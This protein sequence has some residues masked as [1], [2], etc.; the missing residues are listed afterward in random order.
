MGRYNNRRTQQAAEALQSTPARARFS[1]GP[2]FKNDTKKAG[3]R[4]GGRGAGRGGDH[5]GGRGTT[6]TGRRGRGGGRTS[7]TTNHLHVVSK[8]VQKVAEK[9]LES[10]SSTHNMTKKKEASL[11]GVDI[12]KLDEIVLSEETIH[13]INTILGQLEIVTGARRTTNNDD[14]LV[15][16]QSTY[17]EPNE[18]PGESN[19]TNAFSDWNGQSSLPISDGMVQETGGYT[20]YED[21]YDDAVDPTTNT[22]TLVPRTT[23]AS[24]HEAHDPKDPVFLYL[25]NTLSFSK[26][27]AANACRAIDSWGSNK[28]SQT[29]HDNTNNNNDD[30]T[31][32]PTVGGSSETTPSDRSKEDSSS[33]SSRLSIAMDWLCLHLPEEQLNRGFQPNPQADQNTRAGIVPTTPRVVTR[34]KAIPHASISLAPK[35]TEDVKWQQEYWLQQRVADFVQL[36]FPEADAWNACRQVSNHGTTTPALQDW[37]TLRILL[38]ELEQQT[39]TSGQTKEKELLPHDLLEQA[40]TVADEELEALTAI[41]EE[42]EWWESN[43]IRREKCV[44]I[45]LSLGDTAENNSNSHLHVLLRHGYPIH[46]CPLM[47]FYNPDMAPALLLR[48]QKA[49]I[50]H[51]AEIMTDQPLI[52]DLVSF[53]QENV[54][55]I[56]LA[57]KEEQDL[58]QLTEV[59]TE[60]Q[61]TNQSSSNGNGEDDAPLG[62]R[63]MA[64]LKG[65]E[66][67]HDHDET[68]KRQE[69]ERQKRQAAR[70]ELAQSQQANLRYTLGER[71][72]RERQEERYQQE[73]KKHSRAAMMDAFNRGETVEAARLASARAEEEFIRQHSVMKEDSSD[74]VQRRRTTSKR[75]HQ[76]LQ[77][78]SRFRK[79]SVRQRL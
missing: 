18:N 46:S 65:A 67:A 1:K 39:L 79:Q 26:D 64:R 23:L 2:P 60:H 45:S 13:A 62:R 78:M 50:Q 15:G 16:G 31:S 40:H 36:G 38:V 72:V 44:K 8:M 14:N 55:E 9:K 71:A 56:Q 5:G 47:L 43:T 4:T 24:S 12:S 22:V 58:V 49:L 7:G 66:K 41:Y 51:A 52:F 48:I 59:G 25:I 35:L 69:L 54:E 42:C 28:N 11:Q 74:T 17:S 57:F 10:S 77:R 29:N 19:G 3:G 53:L 73:L 33:S 70:V 76:I 21:D 34:Y 27:D 68:L 37:Q 75:R 63:R 30:S 61:T 20:E 32:N 6:T